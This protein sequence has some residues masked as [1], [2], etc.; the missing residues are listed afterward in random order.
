MQC[1]AELIGDHAVKLIS[2]LIKIL[3]ALESV[4]KDRTFHFS[5]LANFAR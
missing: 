1:G 4:S 3:N 2:H 5:H